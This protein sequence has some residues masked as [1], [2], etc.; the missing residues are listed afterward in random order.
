MP[1]TRRE[2]WW[3]R[4]GDLPPDVQA[5]VGDL[6]WDTWRAY[7][8]ARA[9]IRQVL[10]ARHARRSLE[11]AIAV[12]M[13]SDE[14]IFQYGD[15]IVV[16]RPDRRYAYLVACDPRCPVC[17]FVRPCIVGSRHHHFPRA[18]GAYLYLWGSHEGTP[19]L[20]VT[21]VDDWYRVC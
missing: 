16:Q 1:D 14:R 13:R 9:R 3:R 2:W 8:R 5:L 15:T 6:V 18:E 12:D 21:R 20:M 19:R 4:V 17:R 11:C 7:L 10:V